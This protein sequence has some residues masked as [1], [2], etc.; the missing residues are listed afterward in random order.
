MVGEFFIISLLCRISPKNGNGLES[1]SIL[2][3]LKLLKFSIFLIVLLYQIIHSVLILLIHIG[4]SAISL[5][6][7]ALY[8]SKLHT[9]VSVFCFDRFNLFWHLF[10]F[11]YYFLNLTQFGFI[12]FCQACSWSVLLFHIRRKDWFWVVSFGEILLGV[13]TSIIW[14]RNWL[15]TVFAICSVPGMRPFWGIQ[16]FHLQSFLAWFRSEIA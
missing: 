7:V 13:W 14:L 5:V 8:A 12:I 1:K 15:I 11:L 10:Y 16:I 6:V 2:L 9:K 4:Y 3:L